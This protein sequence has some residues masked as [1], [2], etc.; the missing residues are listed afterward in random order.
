[1]TLARFPALFP[2]MTPV[3]ALKLHGTSRRSSASIRGAKR[4]LR[5]MDG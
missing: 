3:P 2:D 1:M 4:G 5:G